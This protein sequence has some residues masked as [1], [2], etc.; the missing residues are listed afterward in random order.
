MSHSMTLQQVAQAC[1]DAGN[2]LPLPA[3]GANNC[4]FTEPW[5]A[6]A[7]AM[8]LVLHARGAFS[9]TRWATALACEIAAARSAGQND[10]G[11]GYYQHWLNALEKIVIEQAI[12]TT[13][14]LHD[15]E[16]A[17]EAAAARTPHG[18]SIVLTASDG[19]QT[20]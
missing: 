16:H 10:D 8:T 6:Q 15:L 7:F 12:G 13:R 2:R 17:W 20:V 4:A 3:G 1:S 11:T 14:E 18:Q 9:W 19:V 5:Q